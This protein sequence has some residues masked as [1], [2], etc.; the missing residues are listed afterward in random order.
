MPLSPT[1]LT[2][3]A[4]SIDLLLDARWTMAYAAGVPDDRP[5]LYAT[6]D[7]RRPG[8]VVV[9]PLLPVAAEWQ[10]I[11][12]MRATGTGLDPSETRRGIHVGHDLVLAAPIVAGTEVHLSARTV[13]VGRRRA[14]ATQTV[15]FTATSEGSVLWRTRMTSLYLG[16]EL[17]GDPVAD[18]TPWPDAP[19]AAPAGAADVAAVSSETSP[20]RTVDAHVYSEC[21]RIWNP[22]H[23]D[24][25][26]AHLAGL[27]SPILHGTATLARSVSIASRLT[28]VPL[29]AIGRVTA[30]FSGQVELGSS[31]DVRV[32]G[33]DRSTVWFDA[34]LPDGATALRDASFTFAT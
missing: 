26:A 22:I 20:V 3:P 29:D 7:T 11:T 9:H 25:V 32:L 30:S 17:A 6:D 28:G 4:Q 23:T 34:V 8:G 14:G 27:R 1:A 5:E 33:V 12:S 31:F 24:V 21:A 10:L 19:A 16:V 13:A 2:A 15:E 18:D